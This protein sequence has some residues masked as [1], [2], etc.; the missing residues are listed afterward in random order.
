V[1]GRTPLEQ[2]GRPY[3]HSVRVLLVRGLKPPDGRVQPLVEHVRWLYATC[4]F[5]RQNCHRTD[6]ATYYP[7]VQLVDQATDITRVS[8][9]RDVQEQLANLLGE[10][11]QAARIADRVAGALG[12]TE[13][14]SPED[15]FWSLRK[16]FE[17]F[18]RRQPTILVFDELHHGTSTLYDL[19]EHLTI[20][21]RR[22]PILIICAASPELLEQRQGWGGG[23]RNAL[24]MTLDPLRQDEA[25]A[26]IDEFVRPVR[27]LSRRGW[28]DVQARLLRTAEGNPLFLIQSLALLGDRGLL[29]RSRDKL[30]PTRKFRAQAV[31]ETLTSVLEERFKRLTARE[32]HTIACAAVIG[33]R[34]PASALLRLVEREWSELRD[35]LIRLLKRT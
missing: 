7:V 20:F 27:R 31:P 13:A 11:P 28:T 21:T 30:L 15:T 2:G 4:P 17:F 1:E 34:F 5:I 10:D 16:L 26:L 25:Q 24:S 29:R 18:A 9:P 23:L 35:D 19:I 14:G 8:K 22:A 3:L 6:D 33:E 32:Q 12:F